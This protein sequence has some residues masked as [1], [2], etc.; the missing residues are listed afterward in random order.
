[1]Y[2]WFFYPP[3]LDF[4]FSSVLFLVFTG[5]LIPID[6]RDCFGLVL[7]DPSDVFCFSSDLLILF[8]LILNVPHH[9]ISL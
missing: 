5:I 7:V 2:T 1:M 4:T 9:R 6:R 8:T 3:L